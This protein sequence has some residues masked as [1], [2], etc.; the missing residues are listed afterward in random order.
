MT[1]TSPRPRSGTRVDLAFGPYDASFASIGATL[2]TLRYE[3]R[4]LVVPFEADEVRPYYRG[5]VLAPW[6]NRVVDG[7]YTDADG[8]LQKLAITEP[9]RGH[10]LHGLTPWLDFAIVD[11]TSTSVMFAATIPAQA[12]Y[13][14]QIAVTVEFWL[15]AAGLHS[16]TRARNDDTVA[17]PLGLS[18]HPYLVGGPGRVGEWSLELPA[19]QILDADE[20]LTPTELGSVE[21]SAFSAY[22]FRSARP[23]GDLEIDHAFTG[24][25]DQGAE[26]VVKVLASDGTGVQLSWPHG[27]WVQIHTADLPD[28][29]ISRLGV[30]VEPMT[31]PPDVFNSDLAAALVQPDETRELS[32]TI[33][34]VNA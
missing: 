29:A 20:R 18:T 30:A 32:F 33:S 2:R 14:H 27:D 21:T 19:V 3:G 6:P 28:P 9:D 31:C 25:T 7:R 1:S 15:D 16:T 8:R 5:T 12:G 4:D 23:I 17:A 24:L 10:A 34:A 26:H 13:P 22:D 11:S